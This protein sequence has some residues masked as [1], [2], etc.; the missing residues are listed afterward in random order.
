VKTP[1]FVRPKKDS[2]GNLIVE[3]ERNGKRETP[4][5][6]EVLAEAFLGSQPAGTTT[7]P[8]RRGLAQLRGHKSP[9]HRNLMNGMLG[10]SG[11]IILI[12]ILR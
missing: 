11:E 6:D 5:L 2:E 1:R 7:C 8:P 12:P 9:L 4:R 3:L 10:A